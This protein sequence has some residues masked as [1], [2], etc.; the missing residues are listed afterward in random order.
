MNFY[1]QI[2]LS[3]VA[4]WLPLK[5]DALTIQFQDLL[6]PQNVLTINDDDALDT[7][8][9]NAYLGRK[10][11]SR[12]FTAPFSFA[13]FNFTQVI[14]QG[15]GFSF[16]GDAEASF[17]DRVRDTLGAQLSLTGSGSV[18]IIVSDLLENGFASGSSRPN[19]YELDTSIVHGQN[20]GATLD[21]SMATYRGNA[22]F[23][24]AE[25][26]HAS[27]PSDYKPSRPFRLPQER[28]GAFVR[29]TP[30]GSLDSYWAT[31]VIT[32]D[33]TGSADATARL[34]AHVSQVPLPLSATALFVA[35]SLLGSLKLR[36][37]N[38]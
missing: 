35:I 14:G 10:Y 20:I 2:V 31:S 27:D 32:I 28:D 8:D 23:D 17:I 11:N 36:R 6:N 5:A 34:H 16:I 25:L 38:V 37:K 26:L 13:G 3:L 22:L 29:N 4:L 7:G 9:P 33:G 21:I 1:K 12:I 15:D 18:Q 30:V 24:M 19:R